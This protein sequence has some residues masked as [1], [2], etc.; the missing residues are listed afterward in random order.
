LAHLHH[1]PPERFG[2]T[3]LATR[4]A[5]LHCVSA[6]LIDAQQGG[7]TI[8]ASVLEDYMQQLQNVNAQRERLHAMLATLW[9]TIGDERAH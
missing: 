7:E 1:Q 6:R 3:V 8:A 5:R 4:S 2:P 9:K